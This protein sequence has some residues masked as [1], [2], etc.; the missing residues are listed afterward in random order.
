M[1][2]TSAMEKLGVAGLRGKQS[3][4]ID[5]VLSGR[6]VI[7]LFPTGTGKTLV[8][9][10]SALCSEGVTVIVSPLVGL[11]QQQCSR[12]AECGICV[13]EAWDGKLRKAGVGEVRVVYTTPEQLAEGSDLRK[14]L[15]AQNV[16]RL[17]VDEA[18]VVVQWDT[19]R[20][21]LV[22]HLRGF[23]FTQMCSPTVRAGQC[24]PSSQACVAHLCHRSLRVLRLQTD[25]QYRRYRNF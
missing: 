18:H 8:Y 15:L 9:E 16:S 22:L 17:V 21:E 23:Q 19:F 20:C 11:L 4:A 25:A 13:L 5:A 14:T 1:D 10:V 7:Y 3:D 2:V 12:L 6:D 24:T